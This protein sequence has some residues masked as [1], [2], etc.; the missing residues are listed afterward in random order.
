MA[1]IGEFFFYDLGDQSGHAKISL[2]IENAEQLVCG[3]HGMREENA[4]F[5]VW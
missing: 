2:T 1:F 3:A 5:S 4:F